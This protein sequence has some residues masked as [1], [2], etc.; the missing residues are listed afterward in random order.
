M[1]GFEASLGFFNVGIVFYVKNWDYGCIFNV[2]G[3]V[4][5]GGFCWGFDFCLPIGDAVKAFYQ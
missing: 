3:G 5:L 4:L 2:V 1:V